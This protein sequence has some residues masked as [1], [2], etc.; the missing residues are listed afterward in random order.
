[1]NISRVKQFYL[2][3]FDKMINED[4]IYISK[5]LNKYEISIFKKLSKEDQ[6]HCV[7]VAYEVENKCNE[8]TNLNKDRLIKIALLHDIGK[9]KCKLN[10][11][12]KSLLVLLDFITKGNIKKYSN[13]KKINTYFN[14]GEDGYKILKD[15]E[16]D[17]DFLDIIK[18]HHNKKIKNDEMDIIR[19]CDDIN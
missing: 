5:Y 11:I 19:L 7:R 8:N 12:D 4:Y 3:F 18:N 2:Y 13:I 6:K 16:Y 1:M 17:E 10:V 9:I 15:K 14:H